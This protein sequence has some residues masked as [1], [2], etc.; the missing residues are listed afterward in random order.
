MITRTV[1]AFLRSRCAISLEIN[2]RIIITRI[3][4]GLI[5]KKQIQQYRIT[6]D[7]LI[8]RTTGL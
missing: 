3:P 2:F 6:A 7:V 4:Y 1:P 8:S 5:L